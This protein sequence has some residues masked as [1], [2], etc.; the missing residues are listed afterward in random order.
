MVRS[1]KHACAVAAL[2]A[3]GTD[4]RIRSGLLS[5]IAASLM[6]LMPVH[7]VAQEAQANEG[8]QG[9]ARPDY[10]AAGRQVG[11]FTLNAAIN[12][13]AGTNDNVFAAEDALAQDD[14]VYG[15]N[16][17]GSLSSN[18][19]RHAL[20]VS[21]GADF[22]RHK[23]LDGEDTESAYLAGYG[24]L[25][26]GRDTNVSA[27]AR[28][29]EETEPRT[30]PDASGVG[31]PVDFSRRDFSIGA[32]HII[33]RFRLSG[34]LGSFDL[35]YNG[36]Q[37][38]RDRN[39]TYATG[40][41]AVAVSP[42]LAL[43]ADVRFDEREYDSQPTL[44]SDGRIISAGV[45]MNLT[46]LVTGEVTVGQFER[47]YSSGVKVDGA[48]FAGNVDWY[49]TPLTTVSF[50]ARRDVE[51]TG[52]SGAATYISSDM[53][54]RIDHEARRNI[55]LSGGL[56]R[57]KR[58]YEAP[59]DREDEVTYAD[60]G[61]EFLVNR[62]LSFDARIDRID[63]TSDGL[64]RDRDFEVNRFTAGVKISL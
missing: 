41:L 6:F 18:W 57:I 2:G 22:N 16:P 39:E 11:G 40:R 36:T 37:N 34:S 12:L 42:R 33:N 8:V 14:I 60:I 45:R 63:N 55:I 44:N 19:I 27:N 20:T 21:A 47:D 46:G 64:N 53:G 31:F 51:E 7:A 59:T 50:R 4:V 25:D 43:L 54:A 17:N 23:D 10:D 61:V 48:A 13:Y 9:R 15:F 30:A 35:D 49:A 1:S 52:A 3:G 62:R 26:I 28:I 32:E 58:E 29:S 38:F 24:R 5:T 56:G